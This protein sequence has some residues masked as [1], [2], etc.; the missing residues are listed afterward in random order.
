MQKFIQEQ[1][2]SFENIAF[3]GDELND[4]KLLRS[5]GLAFAV[6]DA[7]KEVKA[8]ADIICESKG[9]KGAFREAVEIL[10]NL[11][12]VRIESIIDSFL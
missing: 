12:G 6:Y 7:A 9:G 11:K 8:S 1:G 5:V 2:L 10:L 3:I 4:V